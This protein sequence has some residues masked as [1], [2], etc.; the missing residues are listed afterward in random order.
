VKPLAGCSTGQNLAKA[1]AVDFDGTPA[2]IAADKAHQIT[3]TVPDGAT[4]GNVNATTPAG[5]ATSAGHF[6]VT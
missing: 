4:T 2:T 5:T 1:S 6:T 3:V